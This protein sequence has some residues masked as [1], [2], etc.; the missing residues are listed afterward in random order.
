[1]QWNQDRFRPS[2]A[3]TSRKKSL[4]ARTRCVLPPRAAIPHVSSSTSGSLESGCGLP[5]RRRSPLLLDV[6][7]NFVDDGGICYH[8]NHPHLSPASRACHRRDFPNLLDQPRPGLTS[9]LRELVRFRHRFVSRYLGADTGTL[10]PTSSLLPP[11]CIGISNPRGNA[12]SRREWLEW[13]GV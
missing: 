13:R 10:L 8:G 6:P 1:M 9:F 5:L 2:D 12:E 7:E 3:L 11:L 4:Q